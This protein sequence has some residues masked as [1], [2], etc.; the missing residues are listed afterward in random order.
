MWDSKRYNVHFV[1]GPILL[2]KLRVGVRRD[3]VG[4]LKFLLRAAI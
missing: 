4:D 3:P 1:S 2:L